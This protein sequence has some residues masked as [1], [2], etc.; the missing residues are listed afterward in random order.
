[1]D[2]IADVVDADLEQMGDVGSR[3]A[4]ADSNTTIPDVD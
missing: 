3:M 1:V 2:H 4:C